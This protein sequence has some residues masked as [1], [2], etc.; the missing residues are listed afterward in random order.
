M[1]LTDSNYPVKHAGPGKVKVFAPQQMLM[2]GQ[3]IPAHWFKDDGFVVEFADDAPPLREGE[4][5][6]M[7][8]TT[9]L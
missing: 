6:S 5:L 3:I 4:T 2:N 9:T 8:F 1:E 7:T